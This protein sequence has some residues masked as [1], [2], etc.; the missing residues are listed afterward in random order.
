MNCRYCR[1]EKGFWIVQGE[2]YFCN[3]CGKQTIV[4]GD[5]IVG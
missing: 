1:S 4:L 2:I 5:F 3:L